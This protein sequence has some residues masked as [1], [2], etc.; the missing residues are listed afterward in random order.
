MKS[1]HSLFGPMHSLWPTACPKLRGQPLSRK[2]QAAPH[3]PPEAVRSIEKWSM[4]LAPMGFSAFMM[5]SQACL[6]PNKNLITS[7]GPSG[8]TMVIA[9]KR[10]QP[11]TAS[12]STPLP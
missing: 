2:K 3:R 1:T 8:M 4:I 5:M 9:T 12:Q 6:E 7:V 11:K 10:R